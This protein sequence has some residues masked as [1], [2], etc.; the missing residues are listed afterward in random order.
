[1]FFINLWKKAMLMKRSKSPKILLLKWEN[2]S[3]TLKKI[4]GTDNKGSCIYY[5]KNNIGKNTNISTNSKQSSELR[6]QM[7]GK[8]FQI[9]Y[10]TIKIN[11][12]S[13]LGWKGLKLKTNDDVDSE[14]NSN[15][16]R[17]DSPRDPPFHIG[18]P[19]TVQKKG[20]H[21]GIPPNWNE[22]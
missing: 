6:K 22:G 3:K 13:Y 9:N 7:I 11:G 17:R 21:G 20:G 4:H 1:M 8:L 16:N 14:E 10:K 12:N 19:N 18:N 2:T 5:K 15:W